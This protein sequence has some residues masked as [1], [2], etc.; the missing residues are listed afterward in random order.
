MRAAGLSV[1]CLTLLA[2]KLIHTY[3]KAPMVQKTARKS[4]KSKAVVGPA[5]RDA[6]TSNLI[7][8]QVDGWKDIRSHASQTQVKTLSCCGL[9]L[10]LLI[11]VGKLS[12]S[13][14]IPI[15]YRRTLI[16]SSSLFMA[17]V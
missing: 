12:F 10:I 15:S 14:G 5:P 4:K 1:Y 13:L 3:N 16:Y 9:S 2:L 7:D 6:T 8:N 11:I 17:G